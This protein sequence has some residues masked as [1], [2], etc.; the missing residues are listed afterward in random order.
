M[1]KL[2]FL[3]ASLLAGNI[4]SFAPVNSRARYRSPNLKSTLEEEVDCIVIGSG[5]G[6]LSCASLLAATG[7]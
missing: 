7:K 6:G 2:N 5:I 3:L 4:H 1:A